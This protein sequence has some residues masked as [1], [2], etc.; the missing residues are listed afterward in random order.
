MCPTYC[1]VLLKVGFLLRFKN[2]VSK[3]QKIFYVF[4]KLTLFYAGY[5]TDKFYTGSGEGE[6]QKCSTPSI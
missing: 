4:E 3:N 5:L 2:A 6:G 1:I